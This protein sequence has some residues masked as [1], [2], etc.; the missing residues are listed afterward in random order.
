V[1]GLEA[2]APECRD[3]VLRLNVVFVAAIMPTV[4]VV[5]S[6]TTGR[7]FGRL[8][9]SDRSLRAWTWTWKPIWKYWASGC[10][11]IGART[12]SVQPRSWRFSPTSST[13]YTRCGI[14]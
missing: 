10:C 9:K 7:S 12:T 1:L 13:I 11:T 14:F 5:S 8:T 4:R 2:V 3:F 6:R